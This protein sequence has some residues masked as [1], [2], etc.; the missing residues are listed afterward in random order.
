MQKGEAAVGRVFGEPT[1]RIMEPNL[2]ALAYML[3]HL[4]EL[5]FQLIN[6]VVIVF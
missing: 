1:F 2:E 5:T 6:P 4:V 3:Q